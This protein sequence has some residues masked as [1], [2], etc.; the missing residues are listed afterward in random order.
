MQNNVI[1]HK[2]RIHLAYNLHSSPN[3]CKIIL[4]KEY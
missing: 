4:S 1:V 2:N 3:L